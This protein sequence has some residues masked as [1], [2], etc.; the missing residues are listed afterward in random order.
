MDDGSPKKDHLDTAREWANR[1]PRIKLVECAQNRGI[2]GARNFAIE[3]ASGDF[4]AIMDHDDILH[5]MALGTFARV[6]ERRPELEPH[7]LQRVPDQRRGTRTYG[8]FYKPHFD[9]F[10]LLR[11]NYVCHFTAIRRDLLMAAAREGRVFRSEYDGAEDHDLFA[12]VAITGMMKAAAR[13]AVPLLLASGA[14]ELLDVA[15]RQ[16]RDPRAADS[17]CWTSCCPQIY[18]GADVPHRATPTRC[19]ASVTSPIRLARSRAADGLRSSW[20]CRSATTPCGR[21][22]RSTPWR[23]SITT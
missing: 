11:A 19:G 18:P 20:S 10:T 8:Y 3:H 6:L 22:R 12:R 5:P 7:L 1:D 4:F 15:G 13:P 23:S 21:S 16:A 14:D 9:L 2:S 17:A